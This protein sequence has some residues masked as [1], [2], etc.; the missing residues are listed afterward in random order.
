MPIQRGAIR[1]SI[2]FVVSSLAAQALLLASCGHHDTDGANREVAVDLIRAFAYTDTAPRTTEVSMGDPRDRVHLIRGWTA[3]VSLEDGRAGVRTAR[4]ISTVAFH[5]GRT[6]QALVVR[7]ERIPQDDH[8]PTPRARRLQQRMA[9]EVNG[10]ML[11]RLG[12]N[13]ASDPHVLTFDVPVDLLQTGY[14]TISLHH[15][16]AGQSR[17]GAWATPPDV[18][19]RVTFEAARG[20]PPTAVVRNGRLVV[21]PSGEAV[22]H[23]RAPTAPILRLSIAAPPSG[24]TPALLEVVVE[25]P[26]GARRVVRP[27]AQPT[28]G[29]LTLPLPVSPGAVT[30]LTLAARGAEAHA[31]VELAAATIEGQRLTRS[32]AP[33][34]REPGRSDARPNVLLYIADTLRAD[35]LG[36]YGDPRGLTPHLDALARE[37][38]L[39]EQAIAQ[40]SWTRPATASILTGLL[41]ASHGVS[42]PQ[43]QL[44]ETVTTVAEAFKAAGYATAGFVT[45][46]NVSPRFGFGRGF[47]TYEYLPED[48]QRPGLHVQ[49]PALHERVLEWFR[50]NDRRPWFL[51]VHATDVHAPYRPAEE[52]AKRVEP[53]LARAD[54]EAVRQ[55][56]RAQEELSGDDVRL[57]SALYDGEIAGLD[58]A[59]GDLRTRLS[60]D[61]DT[62]IVFVA[63]HGEEFRDHR[64]MEHG[65]TLYGELIRIPFIVRLPG[66]HAGGQ[67]VGTLA[68]QVDL[69]PTVLTLAGLAVP[70]GIDGIPLLDAEGRV[71]AAPAEAIA[72]TRFSRRP[73]W[74]LVTPPWKMVLSE[75]GGRRPAE[76][77]DLTEDPHEKHDLTPDQPLLLGYARERFAEQ[78]ASLATRRPGESSEKELD[79]ETIRRLRAL[80]YVVNDD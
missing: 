34:V 22:F 68:R 60:A 64:G 20:D 51:Y 65:K 78:L 26:Y 46:L 53:E 35:R 7:F 29:P 62:V 73:L 6:P 56:L 23:F 72:E 66:G 69:T 59:F 5:A 47:E 58:T 21:P 44:S 49:A 27:A 67:R 25:T 63:D 80:G 77:Y 76:T 55:R 13:P 38:V 14:N 57:L 9:A 74:A 52:F 33:A 32:S 54:A 40:C 4:R 79:P 37:G 2:A 45:N 30:R 15:S 24:V 36:C 16:R 48:D 28:P 70:E 18:F 31:P 1:R 8:V 42:L 50:A 71:Q 12:H 61:D 10:Q 75:G 19:T 3:P 41:P 11:R 43:D 39:F 17:K